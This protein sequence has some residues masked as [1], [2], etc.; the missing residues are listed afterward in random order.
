MKIPHHARG[1][2]NDGNTSPDPKNVPFPQVIYYKYKFVHIYIY[3]VVHAYIYSLSKTLPRFF[4]GGQD[5]GRPF[6]L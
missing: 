1:F 3:I 5:A 2:P 4:W 6:C